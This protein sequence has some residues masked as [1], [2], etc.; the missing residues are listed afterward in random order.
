[1]RDKSRLTEK[2]SIKLTITRNLDCNLIRYKE[3]ES[4][5]KWVEQKHDALLAEREGIFI[6]SKKMK[7]ELEVVGKEWIEYEANAKAAEAE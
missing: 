2:E 6:S 3:V 5:V 4:E 7:M 1:M